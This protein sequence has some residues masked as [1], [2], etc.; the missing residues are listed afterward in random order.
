M[1]TKDFKKPAESFHRI[2]I[3][4][5]IGGIGWVLGITV[6]LSLIGFLVSKLFEAVGGLPYVGEQIAIIIQATSDALTKR[7]F[8]K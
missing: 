2:F 8:I 7:P 6:G 5:F 4:N 1:E 3:A